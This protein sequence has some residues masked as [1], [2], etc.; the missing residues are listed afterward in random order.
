MIMHYQYISI[1]RGNKS[2][3][4]KLKAA[5]IDPDKYIRFFSL[6]SYDR[7]NRRKVKETKRRFFFYF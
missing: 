7:I 1:C 2:I 4:Q 6:R 3:V 5:G